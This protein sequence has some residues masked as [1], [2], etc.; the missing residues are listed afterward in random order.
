MAPATSSAESTPRAPPSSAAASSRSARTSRSS[1]SPIASRPPSAYRLVERRHWYEVW[2]LRPG[3][4]RVIEHLPLGTET[5][6]GAVPRCGEVLRLA[7][8]TGVR[9]L[10]AVPRERVAVFPLAGSSLET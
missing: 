5:D 1:R 7:A 2:Q 10:V 3:A 4:P 8:L 9:R 6:P